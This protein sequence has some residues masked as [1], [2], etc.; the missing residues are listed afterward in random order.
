MILVD[1][2]LLFY[3]EDA[4]SPK[5][6]EAR[7]W[8]DKTLSGEE[9]IGLAWITCMAYIRIFTNPRAVQSP[10][11]IE[12]ATLTVES[13]LSQPV[14]QI[15]EPSTSF[16][17]I[18]QKLLVESQA[19]ANLSSDAYLAALAIDHDCELCSTDAD[20]SRFKGLRWRNPLEG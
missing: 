15:V 3:S 9:Q 2:N 1:A 5:H 16:W 12:E 19:V 13:W 14:V 11:S 4:L 10:L 7:A 8:W 20:F 17:S 18:L 6:N